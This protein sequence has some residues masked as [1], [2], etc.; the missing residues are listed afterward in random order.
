MVMERPR[1]EGSLDKLRWYCTKG[2][3]VEPTVIQEEAFHCTDLGTQLKPVIEHWMKN[4][5]YRKCK[6][7]GQVEDA[8]L[9]K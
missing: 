7:C 1:P 5:E 3:H 8:E 4:E 9:A 2:N 6:V